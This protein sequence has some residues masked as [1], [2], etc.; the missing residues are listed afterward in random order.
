LIPPYKSTT[1]KSIILPNLSFMNQLL[2][3]QILLFI[4]LAFPIPVNAQLLDNTFSND[5]KFFWGNSSDTEQASDIEID[6]QGR[7][8]VA[9]TTFYD[10]D[11]G[12]ANRGFVFRLTVSGQLDGTFNGDGDNDGVIYIDFPSSSDAL[13]AIALNDNGDILLAGSTN[14]LDGCLYK[15]NGSNGALVTSFGTGGRAT[16]SGTATATFNDVLVLPNQQIVVAGWGAYV[17]GQDID[18]VVARFN[19]NGQKDNSFGTQPGYTNIEFEDDDFANSIARQADGKLVVSGYNW[20]C[21]TTSCDDFSVARLTAGGQMDAGFGTG[22]KILYKT[23]PQSGRAS[24]GYMI[25]HNISN[26]Q[27]ILISGDHTNNYDNFLYR[28]RPN[29]DPDASFGSNGFKEYPTLGLWG[30]IAAQGD[31]KILAGGS[32]SVGFNIMR[33][34]TNGTLDATFG[35][36]GMF[37]ANIGSYASSE[38]IIS[39]GN[40]IYVVGGYT[41]AT[42]D[43]AVVKIKNTNFVT[44]SSPDASMIGMVVYPNPSGGDI[45]VQF[46]TGEAGVAQLRIFNMTGQLVYEMPVEL[47]PDEEQT[48]SL[49]LSDVLSAGSYLLQLQTQQ[50]LACK[51]VV[52]EK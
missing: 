44:S 31:H 33:T 24:N 46:K 4:Q 18:Y 21:S 20:T 2:F 26:E 38:K 32:A 23:S 35:T 6:N 22:G 1:C 48:I 12:N 29:G 3:F 42:A 39:V 19:S 5:G 43:V 16:L 11:E 17:S 36:N 7:I 49:E 9:G 51:K 37:V 45:R 30:P 52:I 25:L 28:L 40:S 13:N 14:T 34:T 27:R 10:P 47:Q 15:L 41:N 50:M 8:L